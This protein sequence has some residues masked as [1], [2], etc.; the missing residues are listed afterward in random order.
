MDSRPR[1]HWGR[2]RAGMTGVGAR[3][4]GWARGWEVGEGDGSPHPRTTDGE[5][6]QDSSTPLRC[7]RNDMWSGEEERVD[8]RPRLHW[9]RRGNNGRVGAGMTGRGFCG[10]GAWRDGR[11]QGSTEKGLKGKAILRWVQNRIGPGEAKKENENRI[12]LSVRPNAEPRLRSTGGEGARRGRGW[13]PAS[14]R[15][16]DGEGMDSCPRLH[17]GRPRAG[18]TG[19]AR[20]WEVGEG[21]GSPHPRGQRMG[22]GWIPALVFIGAGSTRE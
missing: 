10:A 11:P 22:K 19:W 3:M 18:M 21:D 1:L 15:T 20:G 14:A 9:G 6:Q 16:T 13:V 17:W 2:P 5:G 8:S 7:A 12:G 4:T